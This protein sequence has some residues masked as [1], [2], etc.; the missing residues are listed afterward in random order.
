VMILLRLGCFGL[1]VS[2]TIFGGMVARSDLR[3]LGT[4]GV[5]PV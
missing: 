3:W 5:V 2:F 1:R 4:E